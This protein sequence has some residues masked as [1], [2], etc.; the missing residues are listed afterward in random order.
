MQ[1][2]PANQVLPFTKV[3]TPQEKAKFTREWMRFMTVQVCSARQCSSRC[4][5][6][7]VHSC[8]R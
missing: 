8:M 1:G 2:L 3:I 4:M 6:L 5:S 7:H